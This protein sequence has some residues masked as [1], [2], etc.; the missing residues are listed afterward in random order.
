MNSDFDAIKK[1]SDLFFGLKVIGLLL[2]VVASVGN[3][4][5]TLWIDYF[6]RWYADALPGMPVP[7][8]TL[9]VLHGSSFLF[10][11]ALILPLM[12]LAA[13]FIRERIRFAMVLLA[14]VLLVTILQST[15][16]VVGLSLPAITLPTGISNS[17]P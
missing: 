12:G 7:A 13:L 14:V 3:I 6:G 1:V 11:F 10:W 4:V 15:L 5:V 17:H 2:L 9:F 8:L 16:T